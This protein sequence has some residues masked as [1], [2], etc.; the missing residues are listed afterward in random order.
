MIENVKQFP[1]YASK[2]SKAERL[3]IASS[4][5]LR[6]RLNAEEIVIDTTTAARWEKNAHEAYDLSLIHI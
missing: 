3:K 1:F 6:W 5:P 2:R 4:K